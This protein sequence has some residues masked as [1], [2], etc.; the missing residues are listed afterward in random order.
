MQEKSM[1]MGTVN[2]NEIRRALDRMERGITRSVIRWKY[3]KDGRPLP[4]DDALEGQ[5]KQVIDQ[6]HKI[7][8][9]RGRSVWSEFKSV[10]AKQKNKKE[11]DG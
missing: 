11:D 5:S 1:I 4:P 8:A 10:Y 6:A 9:R 3:K 7:I 2:R